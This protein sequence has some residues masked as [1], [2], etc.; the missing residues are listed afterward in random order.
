MPQARGFVTRMKLSVASGSPAVVAEIK[1]ASPSRGLIRENFAP[2]DIAAS[3][4]QGG[5]TCLSVLTDEKYFRGC[6]DY[7]RE[8]REACS[9]PVL[10]KD[11]TVDEFQVWETRLL[12]ADCILL[13]VAVL[14]DSR[15]G[16]FAALATEIGLDV[17]VEVH[18]E[19]ELARAAGLNLTMIGINNRDLTNF[20]TSLDTTID[21]LPAVPHDYL[22]VTE[23]GINSREEVARLRS[24][25]VD[26]FLVGEAFMSA[27]DP[28]KRL[29]EIFFEG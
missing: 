5:A 10:R 16:E 13:I 19:A 21:L 28:G 12:G 18:D 20:T 23:S 11:F 6:D 14:G 7:L 4:Q 26:A 8:A 1:R 17:L 15:L 22:V 25:G 27:A 29:A 9:L 24:S 2:G 3:Y